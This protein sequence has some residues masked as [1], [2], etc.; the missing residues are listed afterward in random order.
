MIWEPWR[1]YPDIKCRM[2]KMIDTSE[3]V[4]KRHCN[5]RSIFHSSKVNPFLPTGLFLYWE[6]CHCILFASF[7]NS[8]MHQIRLFASFPNSG[9]HQIRLFAPFPNSGMHQIRLFPCTPTHQSRCFALF[10]CKECHQSAFC[11]FPTNSGNVFN[12]GILTL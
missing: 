10:R 11:V 2:Y 5:K 4:Q 6:T 1:H 8:G 3:G 9:M 7:P 12:Y